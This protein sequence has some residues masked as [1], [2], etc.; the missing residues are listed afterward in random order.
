VPGLYSYSE[1]CFGPSEEG[2][3]EEGSGEGGGIVKGAKAVGRIFGHRL[4]T[5]TRFDLA[6]LWSGA[7]VT[8]CTPPWELRNVDLD[9]IRAQG[10][11]RIHPEATLFLPR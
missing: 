6:G 11:A 5:A 7:T 2:E 10:S 4:R 8:E 9:H 1:A 3:Q